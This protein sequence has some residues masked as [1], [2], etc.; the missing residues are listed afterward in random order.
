MTVV[1]TWIAVL[2][3]GFFLA[4]VV[5]MWATW[6]AYGTVAMLRRR[7]ARAELEGGT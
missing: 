2:L 6:V 4:T 1:A 5:V 7:D 3:V